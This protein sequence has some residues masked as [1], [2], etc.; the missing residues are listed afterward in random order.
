MR[1][2]VVSAAFLF[3]TFL[4]AQGEWSFAAPTPLNYPADALAVQDYDG[5]GLDDVYVCDQFGPNQLLRSNGDGTFTDLA[6]ALG[7]I[8]TPDDQTVA[9]AWGDYDNDGDPDLYVAARNRPDRL[10]RNDGEAGF[11]DVSAAC[12]LGQLGSPKSVLWADLNNDG[13][14][15]L[16][17]AN[18]NAENVLYAG[19]PTG[20]FTDRTQASGATDTGFSMA[21]L[22]FDHGRDGDQ[23]LL[24]IKDGNQPTLFYENDGTA[25]FTERAATYGL[26]FSGFGM[27]VDAADANNDG[28]LDLYVSNLYANY[29]LFGRPDGTFRFATSSTGTDDFGMGWG[30]T[31]VD[32]DND[33]LPDLYLG[34]EYGFSPFPNVLYRN[35]GDE[36]FAVALPDDPVSNRQSTYAVLPIDA[37]ND[38]RM[39]L[40]TANHLPDQTVELHRNTSAAGRYLKLK[41][42]G[43][44]TNRQA[45]GAAV[46]F[47]DAAGRLHYREVTAGSGWLSQ[48]SSVLHFGLGQA[49]VDS[50]SVTWPG[51]GT[52]NF[53]LPAGKTFTLT[54]GGGVETGIGTGGSV[55]VAGPASEDTLYKVYPNPWRGGALRVVGSVPLRTLELTDARGRTVWRGRPGSAREAVIDVDLPAGVY[56]LRADNSLRSVVRYD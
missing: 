43:T 36:T 54:E 16:Y 40:L 39:D 47:T 27:G 50:V 45:V 5:D 20:V 30:V 2:V 18:I 9:A 3:A 48:K 28:W 49:A 38:G 34:N 14:L 15:D 31:F 42:I 56:W 26:A 25:T 24:L 17:V 22:A 53:G 8:F 23:D 10:L 21:A 1:F 41:L 37:D 6:P 29:F 13:W 35:N 46:R 32:V 12:G 11:T 7:L 33:G 52:E 55:S 4:P 44:N 51:G 19:G